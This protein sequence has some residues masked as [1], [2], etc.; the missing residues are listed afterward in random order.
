MRRIEI[1]RQHIKAMNRRLIKLRQ[2]DKLFNLPQRS[3]PQNILI[4]RRKLPQLT[5]FKNR[6]LSGTIRSPKRKGIGT[7]GIIKAAAGVGSTNIGPPN[8]ISQ[9]RHLI[10]ETDFSEYSL[11]SL[12]KHHS[13]RTIAPSEDCT[14]DRHIEISTQLE[15]L[16]TDPI[17]QPKSGRSIGGLLAAGT[18]KQK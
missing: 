17:K 7:V 15:A 13:H 16:S 12:I 6:K 10:A 5:F 3:T 8:I 9:G 4:E 18:Q 1:G 2:I 14:L 11:A